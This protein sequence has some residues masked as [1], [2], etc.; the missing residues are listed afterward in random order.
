MFN[1][2][3]IANRGAIA[4]RVIRT[5]KKMG[6]TAVAVFAEADRD[7]LHVIQADE[8]YCLGDG[9]ARD[10]YLNQDALFA[11]MQEHGVDAVHPGYGFLSENPDFCLLYPSDAA[12][13]T[14]CVDLVCCRGLHLKHTLHITS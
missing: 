3:L 12:D 7:S 5:L 9:S 11:L 4:T 10:T 1:K 8:S 2:V 6:V 14:P 13:D